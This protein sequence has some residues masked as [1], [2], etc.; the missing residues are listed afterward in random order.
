MEEKERS[1][2]TSCD[3]VLFDIIVKTL[4]YLYPE[5]GGLISLN[6]YQSILTPRK[7]SSINE[8]ICRLNIG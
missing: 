6:F 1:N 5:R 7:R 3:R 2:A 4:L 8:Y